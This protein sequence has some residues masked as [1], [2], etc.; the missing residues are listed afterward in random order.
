MEEYGVMSNKTSTCLYIARE[1]LESARKVGLN[2]SK[3]VE[4]SL[5]EAIAG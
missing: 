2:I 5:I 3:V 4:N 1:V